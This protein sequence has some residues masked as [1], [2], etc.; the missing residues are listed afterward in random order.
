ML[1]KVLT[2]DFTFNDERGSLTQITHGGFNQINAVFTKKGALRGRLHY[3][4]ENKEAFFVIS[5]KVEVTAS[6]DGETETKIFGAGDMFMIDEYVR[7]SFLYLEDTYLVA[8]YSGCVE[9]PG[10]TKDIYEN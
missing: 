7:H 9:K 1:I 5:G 10:G 4:K 6:K 8:M 2:P 3:H